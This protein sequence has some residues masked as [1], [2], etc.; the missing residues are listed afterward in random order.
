MARLT[1]W[2]RALVAWVRSHAR[3]VIAFV[4]A[5]VINFVSLGF[6]GIILYFPVAPVLCLHFAPMSRWEGDWVW[7]TVVM[8]GMGWSFGF[9]IAAVLN[10]RLAA[11]SPAPSPLVRRTIYTGVLWSWDLAV[12]SLVLTFPSN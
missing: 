10:R 11:K 12:W 1:A 2:T 6:L 5:E 9:L 4:A 7:P 3:S 8:A